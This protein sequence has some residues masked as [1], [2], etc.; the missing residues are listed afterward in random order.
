[1][2]TRITILLLLL[3]TTALAQTKSLD[4]YFAQVRAGKYANVP[5]EVSKPE[6][7]NGLLKSRVCARL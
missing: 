3:T 1:M 6:L 2:T 5:V 7:T 4:N